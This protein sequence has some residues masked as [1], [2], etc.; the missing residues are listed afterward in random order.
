MVHR[1][2]RLMFGG[3]KWVFVADRVPSIMQSVPTMNVTVRVHILSE[4]TQKR[5]F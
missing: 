5:N 3:N 4:V 2:H 1:L